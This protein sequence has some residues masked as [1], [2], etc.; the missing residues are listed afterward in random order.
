MQD[1]AIDHRLMRHSLQEG[2][3]NRSQRAERQRLAHQR[4]VVFDLDRSGRADIGAGSAGDAFVRSLAVGGRDFARR[5]AVEESEHVGADDIRSIRAR[6][7]RT[8]CSRR[9]R[10]RT[11]AP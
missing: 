4:L 10:G 9:R 7:I 1:S 2:D 11:W 5:A 6:T 8:G 3:V